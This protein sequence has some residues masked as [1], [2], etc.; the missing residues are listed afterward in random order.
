MSWKQ[1]LIPATAIPIVALLGYGLTRDPNLVKSPLPGREAFDFSAPVLDGDSVRLLD[2]AGKVI[3]LNFWASWCIPCLQ[4]HPH[5]LQVE[6]TYDA[7]Q[8]QILG[9]IY[10][11]S[12]E[13]AR[14]WM[15]QMGGDWP[16]I[17]DDGSRI[18]IDYG[19][20]G[21]PETY[22]VGTDGRIAYKH[23]GPLDRAL[24]IGWIDRLLAEAAEEGAATSGDEAGG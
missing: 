20:Y 14:R 18:A 15:D 17:I 5:L 22:F 9:V 7:S 19:V 6:R 13:N 4:E 16:S 12:E 21:V 23:I 2:Y 24:L 10:Q 3:V 11:D 8:V 1:V